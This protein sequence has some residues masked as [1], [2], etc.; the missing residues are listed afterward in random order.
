M[1]D[2]PMTKTLYALV[3]MVGLT[4]TAMFYYDAFSAPKGTIMKLKEGDPA[5]DFELPSQS[6]QSVRL[7]SF[8]K[9]KNVVLYFYPKDNT[10]GCTQEACNFRKELAQFTSR[11]T[12]VIGV[13]LDSIESHQKFAQKYGLNFKLLSDRDRL[14]AGEYGVIGSLLG[15]RYAKRTT[16]VI[17]KS[18]IIRKIFL[19]VSVRNHN[20]EVLAALRQLSDSPVKPQTN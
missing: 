16:F 15:L 18:G 9:Q 17:D 10:P 11:D 3:A 1:E 4:A 7:S 5:P 13:S 20:D 6:G 8:Q 12:E 2:S 19:N 14:V